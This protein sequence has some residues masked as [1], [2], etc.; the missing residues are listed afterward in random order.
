[1]EAIAWMKQY[2]ERIGDK[3]PDKDGIYLP[4]CLTERKIYE[5]MAEELC[6]SEESKLISFSQFNKLYR[7]EF[8]NVSIPKVSYMYVY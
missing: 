2:F 7:S 8:K 3:R 6:H 1:M 5:V 4:T